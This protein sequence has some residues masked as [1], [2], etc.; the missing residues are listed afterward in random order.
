MKYAS[1]GN[2]Y[3]MLLWTVLDLVEVKIFIVNK[4]KKLFDLMLIGNVQRS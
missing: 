2:F 1:E 3:G 4:I